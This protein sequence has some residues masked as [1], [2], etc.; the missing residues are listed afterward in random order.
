MSIMI[1]FAKIH[2][3]QMHNKKQR[4]ILA[5]SNDL[6]ADNRLHKV[7]TSLTHAGYSVLLV[8]RKLKT[9]KLLPPTL[10]ETKR[11]FLL[12]TK[13]PLFYIFFQIRLCMFLIF[14]R[15]AI[16][17]AN[18]LDTLPAL[19]IV[20][21][22]KGI[23]LIYDSH[24]YFTEVPELVQRP[25]VQKIWKYIE[26]SIVPKLPYMITV[27]DSI[28]NIYENTYHIPVHVI[29]NT[30]YKI[31]NPPNPITIARITK[32][33]IIY[34]GAINI[35]RGLELLIDS[36]QYI[37]TYQLVIIG[38]GDLFENIQ[39][40]IQDKNLH[41]KIICTGKIHFSKLPAYTAGAVLGVSLEENIGKN[42]YYA[43]PNKLFD[44]IQARIPVLVSDLPEMSAIVRTY[45]CGQIVQERT[46]QKLAEQICAIIENT[47][48]Y[49]EYVN[50][51]HK[52]SEIVC[53]EQ[54]EQTL[55]NLYSQ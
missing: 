9:S 48:Q 15:A 45:N 40:Q 13:G 2:K 8:G 21:K 28:A 1:N 54:E 27:C 10:Y 50:N 32:P 33:Y 30:P 25:R 11:L 49:A 44:Y 12:F 20:S 14:K 41:N 26:S 36:M 19:Y 43:L 5:V 51:A 39:T 29:K 18:D 16:I 53:W 52:A 7:C 24:E 4:I 37:E 42:Y 34:Q 3:L 17:T 6:T 22:L 47:N 35:G 31:I 46:A 38:H 55:L 23:K